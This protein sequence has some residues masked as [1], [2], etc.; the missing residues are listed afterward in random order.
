MGSG[1]V[2]EGSAV[3]VCLC[4]EEV[5]WDPLPVRPPGSP[6]TSLLQK[7]QNLQPGPL[8]CSAASPALYTQSLTMLLTWGISKALSLGPDCS[9][10]PR[11]NPTTQAASRE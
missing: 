9:H 11:P 2:S 10:T 6:G 1:N 8:V 3:C 4:L 5:A 7:E